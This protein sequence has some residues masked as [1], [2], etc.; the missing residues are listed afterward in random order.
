MTLHNA[1]TVFVSSTCYDLSE[2][3]S[4]LSTFI[5]GH[6]F[7]PML[8][9][10]NSFPVNPGSDNVENCIRNV[11]KAD[12]FILIVGK[13]FGSVTVADK[14]ITNLEYLHARSNGIP[15]YVF[16]DKTILQWL[17]VWKENPTATF[18]GIDSP[19]LMQF[20]RDL[21]SSDAWSYPFEKGEDIVETLHI[22]WASLFQ[23]SLGVWRKIQ[24]SPV[25]TNLRSLEGEALR[26]IIERPPH[27]EYL[28]Y[29]E[30]LE[31][32]LSELASAKRDAELGIALEGHRQHKSLRE[33]HP[34]LSSMI[35]ALPTLI[36]TVNTLISQDVVTDA[37][38]PQGTPGNP[39]RIVYLADRMAL[40]YGEAI[41]WMQSVRGVVTHE[42][43][44]TLK[45]I[46]AR[47]PSNLIHDV[48]L[49][50]TTFKSEMR[51]LCNNPPKVGENRTIS[52]C[53][54]LTFPETLNEEMNA[55]M[56]RIFPV[57]SSLLLEEE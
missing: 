12:I 22:Q 1:P 30:V 44:D 34:W 15:A 28:L 55:E 54:K 7:K 5:E 19:R 16:I 47:T 48:D 6:G 52:I 51:E 57:L 38:G 53:L 17:P 9:E 20:A 39:E 35:H 31:A 43:F 49:Y 21:R 2:V 46:V 14:S 41:K 4:L 33:F 23:Q 25:P 42:I 8:S 10:Y 32:K 56:E 24:S 18:P 50:L 11:E 29:C 13:R 26:L 3:R 45:G 36:S 27:W 37:F 40:V